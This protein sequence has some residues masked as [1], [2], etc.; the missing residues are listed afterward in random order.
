MGPYVRDLFDE[1]RLGSAPWNR[2]EG[3]AHGMADAIL[4]ASTFDCHGVAHP[5]DMPLHVADQD[6]RMQLCQP[7]KNFMAGDVV[8]IELGCSQACHDLRDQKGRAPILSSRINKLKGISTLP[9]E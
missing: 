9:A 5:E 4:A 7:M 2:C 3:L 6:E 8:E 1:L